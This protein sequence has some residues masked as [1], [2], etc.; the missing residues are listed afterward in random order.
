MANSLKRYW[1]EFDF[2]DDELSRYGYLPISRGCG[3]TAYDY[4]DALHIMRYFLI[5]DKEMLRLGRVIENIDISTIEDMNI[6]PNLGVPVWR[7]V[8][9]PA[10]NL[11]QRA[12]IER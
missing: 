7:G 9:Y 6:I 12:Y 5:Q 1:F 4:D 11:W 10:F 8:W 2:G 3:I